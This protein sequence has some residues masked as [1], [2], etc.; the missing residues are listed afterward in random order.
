[1]NPIPSVLSIQDFCSIG[2]C[3][4]A[5][6][7][8]VL[9]TCGVQPIPLPTSLFSSTPF[10]KH[11]NYLEVQETDHLFLDDWHKNGFKFNAIQTGF[12]AEANHVEIIKDA[13][14]RFANDDTLIVVDPAMADDGKLYAHFN[15]DTVKTM[16]ELISYADMI[17][18]NYTEALM[19]ANKEYSADV[20]SIDEAKAL[21]LELSNNGPAKVIIT[22]IPTANDILRTGLYDAQTE[23]F[24]I[25]DTPH[26]PV[27]APGTGDIFTAI[28]TANILHHHPL[29]EGVRRAVNFIFES[30]KYTVDQGAD[31]GF[32]VL[33]EHMLP[34]LTELNP[35]SAKTVNKNI[36]CK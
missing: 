16:R 2:R 31:P 28:V 26:I 17:T 7:I 9:S 3:S 12:L 13:I 19:L 33:L 35:I 27:Y 4:L 6:T 29:V 5:A 10:F 23:E 24:T 34:K 22:S 21:C 25:M 36:S 8:P 20:I 32:G 11:Y 15:Q 14:K 18:P 30:I 1:M